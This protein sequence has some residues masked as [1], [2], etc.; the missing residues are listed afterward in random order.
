MR[1]QQIMRVWPPG[2]GCGDGPSILDLPTPF[3]S[4]ESQSLVCRWG[5]HG[6]MNTSRPPK[7][8]FQLPGW[9]LGDAS[10]L[11]E[12]ERPLHSHFSVLMEV[13]HVWPRRQQNAGFSR[14]RSPCAIWTRHSDVLGIYIWCNESFYWASQVRDR[15]SDPP[16]AVR[17]L[18]DCDLGRV[19]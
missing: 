4:C 11:W 3:S 1:L 10:V 16:R 8:A 13:D 15:G 12:V 14:I 7:G 2:R 18:P 6:G 19:T 5:A 17:Q 9:Q